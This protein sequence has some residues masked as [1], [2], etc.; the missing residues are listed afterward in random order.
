MSCLAI[1][2]AVYGDAESARAAAHQAIERE[3]AAC[4]NILAPCTSIYR[5]EGKVTQETE[6]PVLF[7]TMPDKRDAL[8]AALAHG[9]DYEIPAI[10][11]WDSDAAHPPFA[12]WVEQETH[13]R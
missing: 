10:I 6:V 7:K 11:S 5:W 12:R 3:L 8:M 2:Y 4:A 13:G 1:V 9:H